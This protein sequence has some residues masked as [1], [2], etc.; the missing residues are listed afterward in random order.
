MACARSVGPAVAPIGVWASGVGCVGS[1]GASLLL[2]VV[3]P[4]TLI[5]G[6]IDFEVANALSGG[7]TAVLIGGPTPTLGIPFGVAL[8]GLGAPGCFWMGPFLVAIPQ[9]ADSAGRAT[10]TLPTE[11]SIFYTELIAQVLGLDPSANSLGLTASN[12]LTVPLN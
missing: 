11:F 3:G 9:L 12:F 6:A 7:T 1:N 2:D 10:L 5:E 4:V 8:E